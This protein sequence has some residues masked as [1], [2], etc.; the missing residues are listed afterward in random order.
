MVLVGFAAAI[1]ISLSKIGVW[2]TVALW[3]AIFG[4]YAAATLLA[5]RLRRKR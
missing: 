2:P 1:L 3:G 5:V 4:L